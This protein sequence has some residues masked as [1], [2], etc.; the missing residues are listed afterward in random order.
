MADRYTYIPYFGLFVMIVWFAGE[1]ISKWKLNFASTALLASA[2]IVIFSIVAFN[3]TSH[4]KN[5]NLLYT[6]TLSSGQG[7][8]ITMHNLC[9]LLTGQNRLAE[10]EAQCRDAIK[11]E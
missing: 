1:L 2:L 6:H 7:N 3:Q 5:G 10:A 11:A 4:W 8:F 9:S